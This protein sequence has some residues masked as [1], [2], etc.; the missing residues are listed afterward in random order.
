MLVDTSRKT[1][2][3][4]GEEIVDNDEVLNIVNENKIL[5]KEDRY[6]NDSFKVIMKGYPDKI[7]ELE[8]ALL[9]YRGEKDLKLLKREFPDKLKFLTKKLAYHMNIFIVSMII[10]NL[11]II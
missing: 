6:K 5:I 4:F 8:E 11:L 7:K 3:L 2:K 9:N 1:L 10:K